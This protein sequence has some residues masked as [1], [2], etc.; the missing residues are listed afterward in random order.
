M[1]A[2][3]LAEIVR[4]YT[5]LQLTPIREENQ[6]VRGELEARTKQLNALDARLTGVETKTAKPAVTW[7]GTHEAG[8]LYTCGEIT[9]KNGL[10]LALKATE[11]TPGTDPSAWQLVLRPRK[12][13]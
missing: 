6:A 11:S 10:W 8:R 5:R 9:M 7:A 1:T 4:D 3:E 2:K 12:D 13:V